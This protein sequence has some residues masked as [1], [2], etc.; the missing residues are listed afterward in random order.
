MESWQVGNYAFTMNHLLQ[1]SADFTIVLCKSLG[2]NGSLSGWWCLSPLSGYLW[3]PGILPKAIEG[4]KV[5]WPRPHF[6]PL[7][8]TT[9]GFGFKE[10]NP[11]QFTPKPQIDADWCPEKT[12]S[13]LTFIIQAIT[14]TLSLLNF[15]S[16]LKSC[17]LGFRK[18]RALLLTAGRASL[19]S[20]VFSSPKKVVE[21]SWVCKGTNISFQVN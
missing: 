17:S 18:M 20:L 4:C 11:R 16:R 6:S 2:S 10:R 19:C 5:R 15:E 13:L 8:K 1:P 9:D 3:T 12:L 7:P 14:S 21:E